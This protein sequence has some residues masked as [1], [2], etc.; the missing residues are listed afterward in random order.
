MTVLEALIKAGV[1]SSKSEARR[2]CRGGGV[3]LISERTVGEDHVI[4]GTTILR[5]GKRRVIKI[6]G[7]EVEGGRDATLTQS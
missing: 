6:H 1:A 5:V 7:P 4:E 3:R 2:L